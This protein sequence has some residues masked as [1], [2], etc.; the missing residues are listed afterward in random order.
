MTTRRLRPG[1]R[2]E[3]NVRGD[4]FTAVVQRVDAG[5]VWIDPPPHRSYRLLRPRQ[6]IQ[7]V[8]AA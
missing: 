1:D 4:I 7:K 3:A 2:V 5:E 6:V 8:A